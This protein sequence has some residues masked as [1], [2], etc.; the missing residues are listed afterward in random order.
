MKGL[1]GLVSVSVAI[2]VVWIRVCWLLIPRVYG[3]RKSD[4]KLKVSGRVW[5]SGQGFAALRWS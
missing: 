3:E 1:V 2:F 4:A 5:S